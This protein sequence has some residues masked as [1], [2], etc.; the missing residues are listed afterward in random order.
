VESG[1]TDLTELIAKIEAY[2]VVDA[3]L[4]L[5]HVNDGWEV[6]CGDVVLGAD[7]PADERAWLYPT[8]TFLAGPL[9]GPVVAQ[10][11]RGRSHVLRDLKVNAPA[12]ATNGIY[13][14]LPSQRLWNHAV[15]PW[16]RTEW[17]ISPAQTPS[18]SSQP[19]LVGNGPPFLDANSAFWAFFYGT[20]PSA[21]ASRPSALW[22]VV[23][24]DRR[25]WLHRVT[26]TPDALTVIVKGTHLD[27]AQ[28]EL[29]TPAGHLLR[30]VGSSN[31]VRLRL[32]RGLP[33]DTLLM[34]RTDADWLDYRHF[35]S[36]GARGGSNADQSVEWELPGARVSLLIA[37]GET[38]SVEFKREVPM[39]DSRKK[40]LKT[41][42]AFA[43][44]QDGGTVLIGVEDDTRVV[45][46]DPTKL[47][48]LMLQLRRMIRDTIDPEPS[49][50]VRAEQVDRKTVL[51][52]EV[53][54]TGRWHGYDRG[55][56][57][58]Y[59]RRGASTVPARFG[60]IEHGFGSGQLSQHA[61]FR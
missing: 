51:L 37:G 55:K 50:Q 53:L 26:V 10:V 17:L 30:R 29:T 19:I 2:P 3:R 39:G 28:V 25:A 23:L 16:P 15:L 44:G 6:R 5:T 4:W 32:P 14:R 21:N 18:S 31:R 46:V 20:A 48:E 59:L 54:G 45:G 43:S 49:Y 34:L 11:M 38:E 36:P 56:P 47:D 57:E 41:V 22:R 13:S 9:P 58:F 24:Q 61:W 60:E 35:P 40:M 7:A 42:A 27:G 1:S 12:S 33:P 8:D 52:I